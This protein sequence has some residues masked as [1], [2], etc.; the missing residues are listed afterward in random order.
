VFEC[1]KDARRQLM[2]FVNS[3]EIVCRSSQTDKY[4]RH[5]AIC[6]SGEIE[7]NKE[8]VRTGWALAFGAYFA[9][10]Q[11]ARRNRLGL[12][13]GQFETP[14]KWRQ[15]KREQHQST[16]LVKILNWLTN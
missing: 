1:G 5:L 12:W 15:D 13:Q 4:Q 10:E 7:L 2:R 6:I 3:I 9:E 11:E 14:S 16:W 8:M